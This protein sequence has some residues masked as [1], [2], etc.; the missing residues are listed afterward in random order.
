MDDTDPEGAV[1]GVDVQPPAQD[2]QSIQ[3]AG[4]VRV[5]TDA[6]NQNVSSGVQN[7]DIN[8]KLGDGR[9]LVFNT[10]LTFCVSAMS[11]ALKMNVIQLIVMKFSDNEVVDAKDIMCKN[12]DNI[13]QYQTRKDSQYRSEKFVH[14]EDIYD[15]LK[16]QS[17]H[18]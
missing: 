15:G 4:D 8:V 11:N 10:L 7:S 1:G 16:K 6:N 14:A 12:S 18:Q 5:G 3:N 17:G 2:V 13:L 9:T